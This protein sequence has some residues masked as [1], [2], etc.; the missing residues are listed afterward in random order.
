[1]NILRG[2]S[3]IT[4]IFFVPLPFS[5]IHINQLQHIDY[6]DLKVDAR[7]SQYLFVG[8]LKSKKKELFK[9]KQWEEL[10]WITN[11]DK[12]TDTRW[13]NRAKPGGRDMTLLLIRFA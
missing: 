11:E 3:L 1:M 10:K 2:I 13:K 12:R 5:L 9:V 7:V 6:Q 4:G 8:I